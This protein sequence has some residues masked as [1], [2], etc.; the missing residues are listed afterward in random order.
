M[1]EHK[2][3]DKHSV[4]GYIV[5]SLVFA[6]LLFYGIANL[7]AGFLFVF[8]VDDYLAMVVGYIISAIPAI[9]LYKALFKGEFNGFFSCPDNKHSLLTGLRAGWIMILYWALL[10][11][12]ALVFGKLQ[13]PGMTALWAALF[14]GIGEEF[15]FRA[16]GLAY[17]ARQSKTNKGIV[18]GLVVT[19][20][21]FGAYHLANL[22]AG[23]GLPITLMQVYGASCMGLVF[24][25]VYLKSGNLLPAIILHGLTDYVCFMDAGQVKDGIQI[26]TTLTI[27]NYI[28]ITACT[29]MIVYVV[30][31]LTRP[32]EL[33]SIRETWAG[34]WNKAQR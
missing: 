10:V 21:L 12:L 19:A 13:R 25:Y 30:F 9:L 34:K 4:L 17:I 23:A 14:A 20:V 29:L 3:L 1:K 15:Q 31:R 26:A 6:W 2:F 33:D 16:F 22:F 27:A 7:I 32:G 24:G 5:I 18:I 28:D 8:G 11:V